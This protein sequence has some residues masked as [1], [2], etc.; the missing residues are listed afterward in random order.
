MKFIHSQTFKT[1]SG[2]IAGFIVGGGIVWYSTY[3]I[4]VVPEVIDDVVI[5]VSSEPIVGKSD[6][7]IN[8]ELS[9]NSAILVKNQPS[10]DSVAID[11]VVLEEDGWV[12]IHEGTEGSI[13]NALGA[14][15]LD[16][17][18]YS[19]SVELLRATIE[20][21]IY[22]A[23]LYRDDGDREFSLDSDFPFMDSSGGP[24]VTMFITSN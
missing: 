6:I 13:G 9:K 21:Q 16:A 14:V 15:R 8:K 3:Q 23:V 7:A 18:E 24:V 22:R 2:F 5:E 19:V 4:D 11:K 10:G 17:G 1:A 12:V 20:G